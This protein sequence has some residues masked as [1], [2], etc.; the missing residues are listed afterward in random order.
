MMLLIHELGH[1]V[2]AKRK[3]LPVSAPVFIPFIG[4]LI[5]MKRHPRDAET[6]AYIAIGGPLFGTIGA[7]VVFF[8]GLYF[9]QDWGQVAEL[10]LV[11]A[12]VGFFLNLINLLPIHPL[13]GGRIATAVT[14]WLWVAGLIGGLFVIIYLKSILFFVVWSLFTWDLFQKYIRKSKEPMQVLE[15]KIQLPIDTV[16]HLVDFLPGERHQSDLPFRTYS[17]LADGQQKLTVWWHLLGVQETFVLPQQGLVKQV[18]IDRVE[19]EPK[20]NPQHLILKVNIGYIPFQA[21]NYYEVPAATR[22]KYGMAYG[23]LAVF[24]GVMMYGVHLLGIHL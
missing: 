20:E 6:E 11:I 21:E 1:V 9:R 12:N 15:G 3:G 14:R 4:A 18:R 16:D 19:R 23:G 5:N 22:W 13:D 8:I 17:Q 24:L 2:A 10:L 7:T